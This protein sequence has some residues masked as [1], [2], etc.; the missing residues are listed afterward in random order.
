MKAAPSNATFCKQ[1]LNMD[2]SM[3]FR[4]FS[5]SSVTVSKA[6]TTI[7][8]TATL[9]SHNFCTCNWK[10]WYLVIFSSS[11]TLT[12]W[13]PGTLTFWWF[14][15]L[16]SLYQWL[17]YLAFA[18]QFPNLPGMQSP[19]V[20]YICHSPA[21]A[22]VDARTFVFIFNV[23]SLAHESVYFFSTFFV[24]LLVW[25]SS[26]DGTHAWKY[27]WHLQLSLWRACIARTCS[28]DQCYFL[29]YLF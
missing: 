18:A 16:S 26:Y 22:L 6:P 1:P 9:T 14:F 29:L 10:S 20:F 23:T 13:S 19:K 15:S 12:F 11:F 17:Q 3:V 4:W 25:V 28:G 8:I 27:G 24:S 7:S 21:L 2:I 5:S